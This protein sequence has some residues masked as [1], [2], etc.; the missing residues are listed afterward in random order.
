M[1]SRARSRTARAAQHPGDV[2]HVG[3]GERQRGRGQAR[4][5]HG[6]GEH[7]EQDRRGTRTGC[8]APT[9]I[10]ESSQPPRQAATIAST[11]A[12]DQR[13]RD[14]RRRAEHRR[15][16][17][18]QQPREQVA[19]LPVEAEQVA[20]ARPEVGVV[21]V[22]AAFGSCG[23]IAEPKMAADSAIAD[24]DRGRRSRPCRSAAPLPR[25]P[26]GDAA[27]GGGD[28]SAHS[29]RLPSATRGSSTR[30]EQVDDR[31]DDHER[32]HQDQRDPLHDREVLRRG[33]AAPARAEAVEAERALDHGRQRDQ[34]R[35]R[36]P[37]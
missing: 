8:P 4:A 13:D 14:D 7:R 6:R 12:G 20:A 37:G 17:A 29:A 23:A 18:H 22:R 30:V 1:Y 16:G 33:R 3:D 2:R 21:E 10:T 26:A 24:H 11:H 32:R 19:A 31:V 27:G 9:E 15:A 28:G 34:R 36:D 25:A 5:E 35:D